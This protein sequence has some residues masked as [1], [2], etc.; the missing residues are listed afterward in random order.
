M[1]FEPLNYT[2]LQHNDAEFYVAYRRKLIDRGIYKM[3]LNIKRNHISYSHT[4]E[5]VDRTLEITES[6]LKEMTNSK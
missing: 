5:D 3:P 2:D 1:N 4:D 6:V